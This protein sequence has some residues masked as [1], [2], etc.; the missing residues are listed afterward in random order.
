LFISS[1]AA[2]AN[3]AMK[4]TSPVLLDEAFHTGRMFGA[5]GTP[6]AVLIDR[7]G[8]VASAVAVGGPAVLALAGIEEDHHE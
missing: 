4:L 8:R 3:R 6:A 1:G 2:E 7:D 5:A